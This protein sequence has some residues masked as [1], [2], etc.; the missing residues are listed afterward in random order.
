MIIRGITFVV[1]TARKFYSS[2][3]LTTPENHV[4]FIDA[5]VSS[6]DLDKLGFT[7]TQPAQTNRPIR[8]P[9]DFR[10]DNLSAINHRRAEHRR[11]ALPGNLCR[12]AIATLSPDLFF[13]WVHN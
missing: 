4:R 6:L 11:R 2:R 1:T 7:R 9:A 13:L 5:F 10:E 3:N 8:D 12:L